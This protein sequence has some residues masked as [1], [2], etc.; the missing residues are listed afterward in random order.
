MNAADQLRAEGRV[1]GRAEGEQ[2]G[3][4]TAILATLSARSVSLS[5]VGQARLASCTDAATLT[6]WVMRAATA[7]SESELFV[8]AE[9]V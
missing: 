6:R 5:E 9:Q 3:L 4:R 2:T 7:T 8:D 1:E